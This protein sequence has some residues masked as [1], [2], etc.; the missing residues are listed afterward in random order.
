[1]QTFLNILWKKSNTHDATL[2]LT[3]TLPHHPNNA[4][5]SYHSFRCRS[6]VDLQI[7]DNKASAPCKHAITVTWQAKFQL[8]PP[9][10]HRC[11]CAEH[12]IRTFMAHFLSILAGVDSS[13]PP[14][15]GTYSYSS[16]KPSSFS[17][18]WD[19]WRSILGSVPAN[20]KSIV[21]KQG[22]TTS[23]NSNLPLFLESYIRIYR[24]FG[25][26]VLIFD[27]HIWYSV[28]VISLNS[29]LHP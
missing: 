4:L 19:S 1:M 20:I 13:F 9:D 28:V 11:N 17:T 18:Y 6:T 2:T 15:F 7:L 8:V 3:L 26:F 14:Y 5:L 25:H 24:F 23:L 22:W 16:R 21:S 29:N 10:M 12:A 27:A